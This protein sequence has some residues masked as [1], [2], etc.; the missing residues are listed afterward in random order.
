MGILNMTPDSFY[1]GGK[2]ESEEKI[3]NTVLEYVENGVDIIDIGG[4]STRP[5]AEKVQADKEIQRVLPVLKLV[6]S[7]CKIPVSID[8]YKPEVAETCIKNGADLINDVYGLRQTGMAQLIAKHNIPVIIMHMNGEPGTMQQNPLKDF[9]INKVIDFLKNQAEMAVNSGI[10]KENVILDPGIGFGK[11]QD[12]NIRL[13]AETEKLMSL[14]FPVVIGASRKS[15]IGALTNEPVE[16]RM[17][18]SVLV[19]MIAVL[20]GYSIIRTHD[21]KET[22]QMIKIYNAFKNRTLQ[23][24]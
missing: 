13:I 6:K 21:V 19:H 22:Y 8:T 5:G 3:K 12:L 2:Y 17:L 1:D 16:K 4:E 14:G 20:N 7:I 9:E 11:E 18:G 10:Q 24:L 15:L 23:K